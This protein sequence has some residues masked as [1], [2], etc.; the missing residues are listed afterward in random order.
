MEARNM[1]SVSGAHS[2]AESVSMW[3]NAQADAL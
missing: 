2:Q 3:V 1:L